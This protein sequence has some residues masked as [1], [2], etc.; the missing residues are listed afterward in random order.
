MRKIKMRILSIIVILSLSGCSTLKYEFEYLKQRGEAKSSDE[1]IAWDKAKI[2][3]AERCAE[4]TS[5]YQGH[6]KV[7]SVSFG[8]EDYLE[9]VSDYLDEVLD[10]TDHCLSDKAAIIME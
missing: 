8:K 7:V 4:I 10:V 6:S 1:Y 9:T 5:I 3:I 2:I